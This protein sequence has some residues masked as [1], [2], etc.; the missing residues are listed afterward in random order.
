MQFKRMIDKIGVFGSQGCNRKDIWIIVEV[1][2]NYLSISNYY[3]KIE[4][5]FLNILIKF[6][7]ILKHTTKAALFSAAF[8]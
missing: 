5:L 8:Q 1:V 7:H 2:E 3:A 6:I 4:K